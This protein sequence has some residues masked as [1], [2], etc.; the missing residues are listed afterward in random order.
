MKFVFCIFL[1]LTLP[2]SVNSQTAEETVK[3]IWANVSE[4]NSDYENIEIVNSTTVEFKRNIGG[5]FSDNFCYATINFRAARFQYEYVSSR[6]ND[7][8]DAIVNDAA[9]TDA[10]WIYDDNVELKNGGFGKA[11]CFNRLVIHDQDVARRLTK[12]MNHLASL[13]KDPFD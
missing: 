7:L 6:N 13:L 1:T 4:D 11:G 3:Y 2:I 10:Y 8:G 12:A 9:G 5:L